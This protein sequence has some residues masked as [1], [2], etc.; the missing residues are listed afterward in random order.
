MDNQLSLTDEQLFIKKKQIFMQ[1]VL[2]GVANG[3]KECDEITEDQFR[4]ILAEFGNTDIAR[5]TKGTIDYMIR[6][7]GYKAIIFS[8]NFLMSF[9]GQYWK[10]HAQLLVVSDQP[11]FYFE[12]YLQPVQAQ[13][14]WK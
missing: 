9:F 3:L 12:Q 7:G 4:V 14:E 1:A 13:N 6:N 2:Q 5:D 10:E 11:L 8:K